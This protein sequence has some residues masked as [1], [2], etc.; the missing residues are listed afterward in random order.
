VRFIRLNHGGPNWDD[1]MQSNRASDINFLKQF[2]EATDFKVAKTSE[3]HP[4]R[5]LKDYPK[6]FAPPFVYIT[7]TG[8]INASSGDIKILRDYLLDGGMLFAD[9]G[10]P[11]FDASFKSL[12][13]AVFP[14]KMLVTI[15]DD[16]VLFRE[17]YIL[18][19]GAPPLYHHGGFKAK[20]V[21]HRDRWCVFYHPGDLKD[22]FRIG[23]SGMSPSTVKEAY[24]LGTNVIYYAFTKYLE[25]TRQDRK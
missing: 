4:I 19:N 16:D 13:S 2:H 20:G 15:A 8:A 18:P 14:D 23:S 25:A 21:K 12:M 7:G 10:S 6:G 3:S 11:A 5:M 1:G 22:A 17:P 9:A 24:N